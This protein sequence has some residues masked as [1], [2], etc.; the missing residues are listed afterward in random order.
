[1]SA[2]APMLR[3]N[4][5]PSKS[6]ARVGDLKLKRF[7]TLTPAAAAEISDD[8]IFFSYL[9][10]YYF[11]SRPL[12]M[13]AS[14]FRVCCPIYTAKFSKTLFFSGLPWIWLLPLLF[15]R[16]SPPFESASWR[17]SSPPR[18]LGTLLLR[19]FCAARFFI[20]RFCQFLLKTR[21]TGWEVCG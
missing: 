21:T 12:S 10:K 7:L 1:M 5:I 8:I 9:R 6:A 2:T 16:V 19:W 4:G 11:F 3:C 20:V 18:P 14:P 15:G 13:C 17:E